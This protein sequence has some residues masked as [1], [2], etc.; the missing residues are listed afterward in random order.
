[1]RQRCS[2]FAEADAS[3]AAPTCTATIAFTAAGWSRLAVKVRCS[4]ASGVSFRIRVQAPAPPPSQ[5]RVCQRLAVDL[6]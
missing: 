5:Q 4:R 3:A 1:M 2:R 6:Q